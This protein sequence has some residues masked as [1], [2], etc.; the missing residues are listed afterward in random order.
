[1]SPCIR[2]HPEVGW[3]AANYKNKETPPTLF[4]SAWKKKGSPLQIRVGLSRCVGLCVFWVCKTKLCT[5]YAKL[6][7]YRLTARRFRRLCLRTPTTTRSAPG[8]RSLQNPCAPIPIGGGSGQWLGGGT[9]ASVEHE[10]I[11][12]VW[13]RAPS[14]V[15]GQSPWSGGQGS[16]AP[17]SWKHFGHWM[18]NGAGKFSTSSWKQYVLLRST[19]V[20]VGGPRVHGAPQPR[21]WGGGVAPPGPSG[22]AAYANTVEYAILVYTPL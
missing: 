18:S 6:P 2:P 3:T 22:S 17:W 7:V 5:F 15:Q 19:G 20:R 8:R 10:P 12:G 21:H 9:M 14:W 13:S 4:L 1:M 11:T 16:E